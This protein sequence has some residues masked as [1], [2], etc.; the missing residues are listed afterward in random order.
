MPVPFAN[1]LVRA[2]ALALAG[3]AGAAQAPALRFDTAFGAGAAPAA[4]HARIRYHSGDGVHRLELW[5]DGDTRLR[6]DTD[7][8]LTTVATRRAGDAAYRLDLFDHVRRIH[9][10]I[11]RDSLY[12]VGRF[13]DW[14]DLARG[15]RH[16]HGTYRLRSLAAVRTPVAPIAP[17]RWY[18]LDTG[19]RRTSICWSAADSLPLLILGPAGEPVWRVD[20]LDRRATPIGL[21]RPNPAGYVL[22]DASSDISDD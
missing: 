12:R 16:P 19:G 14:A 21:Y 2:A 17:C 5:R 7:G 9:S 11:D 20:A 3:G 1:K 22:N 8:R 15:L 6:R 18:M 4:V 13:T 10:V